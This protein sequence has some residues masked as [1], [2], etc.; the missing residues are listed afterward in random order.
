MAFYNTFSALTLALAAA[1]VAAPT[2]GVA[3]QTEAPEPPAAQE[4]PDFDPSEEQLEAF[5]A[6]TV[7]IVEIQQQAQEAMQSA[8]QESGLTIDEYNAIAQKAQTDQDVD[9]QL[10]GLIGQELGG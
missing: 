5:A 9:E 4:Q 7:R 3:Q 6:A 2:I 8:V 10:R 1:L